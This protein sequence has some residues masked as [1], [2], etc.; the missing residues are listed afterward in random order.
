MSKIVIAHYWTYPK[1]AYKCGFCGQIQFSSKKK[2]R[3][4]KTRFIE[5]NYI[6]NPLLSLMICRHCWGSDIKQEAMLKGFREENV[7]RFKEFAEKFG[8]ES[9]DLKDMT[10]T[11]TND[12][13]IKLADGRIIDPP[14]RKDK[15][16]ES[17]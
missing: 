11:V 15:K 9:D 12:K 13:K 2:G 3:C 5:S 7:I 10:A 17:S 16:E 1:Q 14:P 6:G 8:F 4:R